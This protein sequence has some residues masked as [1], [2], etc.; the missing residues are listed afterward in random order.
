VEFHNESDL[1]A[2]LVKNHGSLISNG[3]VTTSNGSPVSSNGGGVVFQDIVKEANKLAAFL[4]DEIEIYYTTYTPA[5][6]QRTYSFLNSVR[7]GEPDVS[8][9]GTVSIEI[10]FDPELATHDSIL[11]GEAGYVPILLNEV[12]QWSGK[13]GELGPYRFARYEPKMHGRQFI[14][15]AIERYVASLGGDRGAIEV[16]KKMMFHGKVIL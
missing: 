16:M 10:H 9:D 4:N 7:V 1:A 11:G 15:N 2:W 14:E 3:H 8:A 12:W 6:Y 5:V 13:K